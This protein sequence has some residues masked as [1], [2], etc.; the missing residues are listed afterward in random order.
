[1]INWG[2]LKTDWKAAMNDPS[3]T[4]NKDVVV[5]KMVDALKVQMDQ[6]GLIGST[7]DGA[8]LV[9]PTTKIV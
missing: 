8:T 7:S 5:D 3:T 2:Q 1:M 9:T 4:N 6:A